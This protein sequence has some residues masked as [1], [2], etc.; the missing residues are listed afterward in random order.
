[1]AISNTALHTEDGYSYNLSI[2]ICLPHHK[3]PGL[4]C[5]FLQLLFFSQYPV[6]CCSSPHL[7]FL[8]AP[9]FILH[10]RPCN[11]LSISLFFLIIFLLPVL[12]VS[13]HF[14]SGRAQHCCPP[15]TLFYLMALH[16]AHVCLFLL[17]WEHSMAYIQLSCQSTTASLAREKK[18]GWKEWLCRVCVWG[19][20]G[21][22][23]R[24]H[25]ST[26]VYFIHGRTWLY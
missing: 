9:T 15:L 1:M 12:S 13:V 8:C 26:C 5:F 4:L 18:Q 17:Y 7:H 25:F 10:L 2:F 23:V 11:Q 16:L 14:V 6:I 24:N 21:V 20:V 22:C 19:G 3:S